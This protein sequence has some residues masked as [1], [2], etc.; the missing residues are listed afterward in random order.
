M[1]DYF[2]PPFF[3][4]AFICVRPI[5]FYNVNSIALYLEVF[6]EEFILFVPGK[7]DCDSCI[8]TPRHIYIER[9]GLLY[10]YSNV[11]YLRTISYVVIVLL[12]NSFLNLSKFIGFSVIS[13]FFDRSSFIIL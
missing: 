8:I 2:L 5:N 1:A 3:C 13:C 10:L 11:D 9:E 7:H 12:P 4:L 6:I